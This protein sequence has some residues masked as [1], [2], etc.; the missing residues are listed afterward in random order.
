M[1]KTEVEYFSE[2]LKWHR[3]KHLKISQADIADY[4]E[5]SKTQW[6]KIENGQEEPSIAIL[7]K[8]ANLGADMNY[9]FDNS[10]INLT[11]SEHEI[12]EQYRLATTQGRMTIEYVAHNIEKKT[13]EELEAERK[14]LENAMKWHNMVVHRE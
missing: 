3:K 11:E 4:L 9:L 1:N 12:I 7:S 6:V 14:F 5:I 10:S 13:P 8:L 2:R